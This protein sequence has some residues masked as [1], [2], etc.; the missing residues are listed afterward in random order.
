M[1][2]RIPKLSGAEVNVIDAKKIHIFD[3]PC[4]SRSPHAKVQIGGVYAGKAI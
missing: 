2:D 3:M 1:R 4:K